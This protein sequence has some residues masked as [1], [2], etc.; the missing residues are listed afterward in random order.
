VI[1]EDP[2]EYIPAGPSVWEVRT[3]RD[4][5]RKAEQDYAAR[6]SVPFDYELKDA[7]FIL[8]TPRRRDGR[9]EWAEKRPLKAFG[10]GFAPTDA[11]RGPIRLG[12][13]WPRQM[14]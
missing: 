5:K 12:R 6:P 1:V 11:P 3:S 8:V 9:H 4:P 2:T 13:F 14:L 10:R 7:T